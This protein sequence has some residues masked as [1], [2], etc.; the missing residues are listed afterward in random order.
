MSDEIKKQEEV[1]LAAWIE[2]RRTAKELEAEV[3]EAPIHE[4]E[5]FRDAEQKAFEA[6]RVEDGLLRKMREN[7][8]ND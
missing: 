2:L 8:E 4:W 6:W 3:R 5:T 7:N 1:V